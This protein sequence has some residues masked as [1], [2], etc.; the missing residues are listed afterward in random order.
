MTTW[1]GT[2]SRRR[3]MNRTST[4]LLWLGFTVVIARGVSADQPGSTLP[5]TVTLAQVMQ[6]LNE[7]S[8]RTLAERASVNVVAADRITA[9]TWPNPSLS[10]GGLH[11]VSGS[12]TGAVTQ[13]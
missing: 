2:H 7:R 13:H 4:V 9:K 3:V 1:H 10:Y 11:L 12:S 6:L 5:A 8:P